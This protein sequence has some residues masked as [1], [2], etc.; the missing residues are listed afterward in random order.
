MKIVTQ[1]IGD[2]LNILKRNGYFIPKFKWINDIELGLILWELWFDV[3]NMNSKEFIGFVGRY[4]ENYTSGWW[5]MVK[6]SQLSHKKWIIK[7]FVYVWMYGFQLHNES[8]R[9][10]KKLL[11]LQYGISEWWNSVIS[12][13]N[14]RKVE[15]KC[16]EKLLKIIH[17]WYK[18]QTGFS[19][20]RFIN[21]TIIPMINKMKSDWINHDTIKEL[22]VD[23]YKWKIIPWGLI[24]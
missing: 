4:P 7:K 14:K 22:I 15:I 5:H 18:N 19:E 20:E 16:W 13:K 12:M 11:A 9:L 8:F 1:K 2:L 10:Y 24:N 6:P 17:N 3:Y 23:V 21:D